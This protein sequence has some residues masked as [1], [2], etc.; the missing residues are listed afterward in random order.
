MKRKGWLIVF[1]FYLII[2]SAIVALA[3]YLGHIVL[4]M[5][6]WLVFGLAILSIIAFTL[7]T[8]AALLIGFKRRRRQ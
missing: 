4:N 1:V 7:G 6:T 3:Y 5:P 8:A 2:S